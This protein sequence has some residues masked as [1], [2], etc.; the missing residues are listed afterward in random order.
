MPWHLNHLKH[1]TILEHKSNIADFGCNVLAIHLLA[2]VSNTLTLHYIVTNIASVIT[3]MMRSGCTR[4]PLTLFFLRLNIIL[5]RNIKICACSW[6]LLL[7]LLLIMMMV[8]NRICYAQNYYFVSS[9]R[10]TSKYK[11]ATIIIFGNH[12][13][14][15][16]LLQTEWNL[17]SI[18]P[19]QTNTPKHIN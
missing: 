12:N 10:T 3:W 17:R 11:H 16:Y 14:V 15:V 7:L 2:F 1:W 13:T 5:N 9:I 6:S 4:S 18:L 8:Y 19:I